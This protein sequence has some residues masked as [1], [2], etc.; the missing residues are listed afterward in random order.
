ML[1][2]TRDDT[3]TVPQAPALPGLVF[4]RFR[5]E[6]D[7]PHMMRVLAASEAADGNE[8]IVTLDE[9]R[10]TYAHLPETD[11]AR[12]IL[13]AE[14][15]GQ[16]AAY[17]RVESFREPDGPRLY[18]HFA[19]MDPAWRRRGLGRAMLAWFQ[20]RLR[21][22]AA[23][24]P[25]D[26]P[27]FFQSFASDRAPGTE[28][29][30]QQ[31]GYTAVRFGYLMV[32]PDLENIPDF[33]LPEGLEVRPVQ[34]EHYRAI[35]DAN[36]EAFRDHWGFVE[37]TEAD[38]DAWLN[39]PVTFT[40]ELWQIAWDAATGQVAGQVK[41]FINRGE[42]E[43]FGRGRGWCEFIS[44]RRPWR[45]R[46]LARALIARTLRAFKER[47]MTESALGVDTQNLSGALRVYE[48]CGFRPVQ[49]SA[50]YRKPML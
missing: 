44:V 31:A 18:N 12:D 33:P 3:L 25:A 6:A 24:H 49:R 11:P 28:A 1:T 42:N 40:P 36:T 39:D 5:G 43:R 47:G 9:I 22:I 20:N 41:G 32:R 45:K 13:L 30:L 15:H 37:P 14:V 38:Y 23:G 27:R 21:E 16:L 35:W 8:R 29:L 48:A 17:G 26:A 50:T 34:P 10:N 19:M 2:T 7:F 46:G 4:R